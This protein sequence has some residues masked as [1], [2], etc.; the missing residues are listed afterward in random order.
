MNP[1]PPQTKKLS[2]KNRVLLIATLIALPMATGC[3][4][5]NFSV[6][7]FPYI[8]ATPA[9]V[10]FVVGSVNPGQTTIQYVSIINTGDAPLKISDIRLSYDALSEDE[11]PGNMALEL[12]EDFGLPTTVDIFGG[13][14]NSELRLAVQYRRID[15]QP[16]TAKLQIV[17]DAVNASNF[18]MDVVVE[19]GE[20]TM[21]VSP[22]LVNF[23]NIQAG[24]AP[25]Q[26]VN[27]LNIGN[28]KLLISQFVLSGDSYFSVLIGEQTYEMNQEVVFDPPLEIDP[29][30]KTT[31]QVR[32]APV[33]AVPSS[34]ELIIF[35]NT[36]NS[37]DG[38]V[39]PITGNDLGPCIE[40][41]PN[42][43]NFGAKLMGGTMSEIDVTVQ[44]CGKEPLEIIQARLSTP[45]DESDE[46]LTALGVTAS[47]GQFS[48]DFTE[49]TVDG[50]PPTSALPWTLMVGGQ[51]LFAVR[52]T[53]PDTESP[54][55]ANGSP[56]PDRGFVVLQTNAF[57]EWV[58]V[59]LT[60]YSVPV[61]CP[62]AVIEIEEG[63]NVIPQTTLHLDGTSSVA[64][65]GATINDYKWSVNQPTGSVSQLL[66]GDTFPTPVFEVNVAGEYVFQ[67]SV[68]DTTGWE[69]CEPATQVVV[70]TPD[71]A[72]H[73]EL[74]WSTLGDPDEFD[75]GPKV[76]TD[77]DLHVVHEYSGGQDL[78]GD[79]L[80]DGYFDE[81][82]DCFWYN[83]FPEWGTVDPNLDDN[84]GLDRDDTD[85]AGPENMNLSVPEDG[86][87]YKVGVHYWKDPKSPDFP[88]GF[89][90]SLATV[91]VYI[92]GQEV[93][94]KE[95]VNLV[96][97]DMWEVCE[98]AWPEQ[99][100]KPIFGL[101]PGGMKIIPNYNNPFF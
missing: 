54:K 64:T 89:G 83:P 30:Q 52:Y 101:G 57:T 6:E 56:I 77:L 51:G 2:F 58:P 68:W 66:P 11:G 40:V 71:E 44:S 41:I 76:G 65:S 8:E 62:T 100:V 18:E 61:L 24:E 15:D 59:E 42:A 97:K 19:Q 1:T 99:T 92:F 5:E 7:A 90:P 9:K 3:G 10:S 14:S 21:V 12:I 85:G 37:L 55:D 88:M 73:V 17:S 49:G 50:N 47:S 91:R 34:A 43:V 81:K 96:E 72:I 45:E 16:R 63:T 69:S 74:L 93:W 79:G 23:K 29:Q 22:D 4:G 75:E 27:I 70:V 78:D 60:G 46:T 98:I 87:T 67:L 28:A 32:F 53:T 33:D 26:D 48:L 36:S 86:I 80:A 95:D 94:K 35:A 39:L 20:A 25:V 31:F 82:W 38:Y 13:A 84:P